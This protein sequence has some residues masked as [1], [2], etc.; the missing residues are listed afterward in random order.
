MKITI[1]IPDEYAKPFLDEL[2]MILKR[3]DVDIDWER[4]EK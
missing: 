3:I 4:S 2:K 1:E